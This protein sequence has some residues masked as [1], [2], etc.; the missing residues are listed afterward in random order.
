MFKIGDKIRL[1]K[2]PGVEGRYS[3]VL[4]VSD[5]TPSG[6]I[7]IKEFEIPEHTF[8]YAEFEPI[9]LQDLMKET[10]S[11]D[12]PNHYNSG[13]IEVIDFIEEQKLGFC[14]GNVVKYISRAA[15]KGK[16]LEDL[17]KA[18]WYLEREISREEKEIN[19]ASV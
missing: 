7:T 18:K 14:L 8:S 2:Y 9:D 13:K 10:N 12:H 19:S 6:N 11:V 5:V 17:K 3:G 16:Y 15:H 1:K 4:T